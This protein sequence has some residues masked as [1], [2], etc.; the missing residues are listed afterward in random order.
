MCYIFALTI[1]LTIPIY[2]IYREP[3]SFVVVQSDTVL[4]RVA[5]F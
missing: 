4:G 5:C 3:A 2:S 1:P